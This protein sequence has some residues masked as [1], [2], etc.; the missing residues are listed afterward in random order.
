MASFGDERPSQVEERLQA[1]N[2]AAQA[3]REQFAQQMEAA[4]KQGYAEGF[5]QG[6]AQGLQ[7]GHDEGHAS[8]KAE[9]DAELTAWYKLSQSFAE[10]LAQADQVVAR[11]VLALALDLTQAMLKSSLELQ[12][13][14][15]L[16]IV[17]EALDQLPSVQPPAQMF[18][19]PADAETVKA[20]FG[21]EL[22][23]DGWRIVADS[24]MEAGGC[25]LETPQN[26]VDA[27]M[28]TRWHKLT[29]AMQKSLT[30]R[31]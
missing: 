20:A 27:S 14:L 25:R 28:S 10:R 4:Q 22:E 6:V 30:T 18:L 21:E 13:E 24:H 31:G 23:K 29:D 5:K 8:G 12:P 11:D 9:V 26:I 16:P 3:S 15:I 7:E 17:R 2:Q 19:N 1:A